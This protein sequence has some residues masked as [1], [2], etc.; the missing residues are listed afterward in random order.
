MSLPAIIMPEA[1]E[2]LWTNA[3]W[4]A[5]NRSL[6]QTQRWYD[7]FAKAILGLSDHPRRFPI[8]RESDQLPYEV[9]VMNYGVGSRPTH[10][11][12]YTIRPD[13]IVVVSIRSAAQ[14]DANPDDL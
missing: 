7:G 1:E 11:A 13:S 5:N 4:W 6:E 2:A 9:R 12:L 8:A 14:Q 10:R 3:E